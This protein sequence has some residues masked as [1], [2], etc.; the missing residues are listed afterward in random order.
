MAAIGTRESVRRVDPTSFVLNSTQAMAIFKAGRM[1]H[2]QATAR[3]TL[4][5]KLQ[6]L[7]RLLS[8][9]SNPTSTGSDL[10]IPGI[11]A[12]D[13]ARNYSL[14]RSKAVERA[15]MEE[16]LRVV[17]L[18]Q[19]D[20]R[21]MDD[22]IIKGEE[23]PEVARHECLANGCH[24]IIRVPPREVLVYTAVSEAIWFA[25][26]N[27]TFFGPSEWCPDDTPTFDGLFP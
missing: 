26:Y 14:A 12:E 9:T 20:L 15:A 1:S 13:E 8:W 17:T 4:S 6:S 23:H 27:N 11:G 5:T 19:R 25:T 16:L 22:D 10:G 21:S 7:L 3:M 2:D 18:A 24:N